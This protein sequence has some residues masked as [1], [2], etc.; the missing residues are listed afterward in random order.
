MEDSEPKWVISLLDIIRINSL[1]L[2]D[3]HKYLY[4]INEKNMNM[5]YVYIL[6]L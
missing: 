6:Y 3:L 1:M 4:E 5:I 2:E